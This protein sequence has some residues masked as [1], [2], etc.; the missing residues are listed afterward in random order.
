MSKKKTKSFNSHVYDIA[1]RRL[2]L[3]RREKIIFFRLLGFLIRND[4]PFPF[5]RKSLSELTGYAKSSIDMALNNLEYFRLISR[6]GCTNRTRFIR[7]SI[8]CKIFTLAQLR[9]NNDLIKNCT[10]AQPLGKFL[11]TSPKVGYKKTYSS[12]KLKEREVEISQELKNGYQEYFGDMRSKMRLRLISENTRILSIE[13]WI[14][15]TVGKT[16]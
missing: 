12:L 11:P 14:I 7:G 15:A 3:Q 4:K 10:L 16:G 5:S 13:D 6:V 8:L 9:I 2:Y 1:C